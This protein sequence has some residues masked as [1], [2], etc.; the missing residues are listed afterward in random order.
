VGA[1]LILSLGFSA[2]EGRNQLFLRDELKALEQQE[3]LL[4]QQMHQL[5]SKRND[6][7]RQITIIRS[8]NEQAD[9]KVGE[10]LKLRGELAQ[11]RKS[12]LARD[13]ANPLDLSLEAEMKSWLGKVD[14]LKQYAQKHPHKTI[15]E[16]QYLT[17]REW[18]GAASRL[19]DKEL[20]DEKA[21]TSLMTHLCEQ[22][23]VSFGSVIAHSLKKYVAETDAFPSEL[24]Q[25]ERYCD[26][27]VMDILLKHYEIRPFPR[28]KSIFNPRFEWMI[29]R[30]EPMRQDFRRAILPEGI[31]LWRSEE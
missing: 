29:T 14:L 10:V 24:K 13:W 4:S 25:L 12:S 21:Y 11:L 28:D 18:L 20:N 17:A 30:K 19:T 2:Y 5:V 23:E 26:S 16:I 1:L 3:A 9:K 6:A 27:A 31:D 8:E 7:N 15:P 22:A